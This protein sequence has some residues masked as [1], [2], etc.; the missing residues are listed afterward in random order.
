MTQANDVEQIPSNQRKKNVEKII[1]KIETQK[2]LLEEPKRVSYKIL[3]VKNLKF[4]KIRDLRESTL[5]D[6]KINIKENG[7]SDARVLAVVK[8]NSEDFVVDGNHRLQALIDL[9]I[10]AVPCVVYENVDPYQVAIEGNIAENTYAPMDLFDWL[11]I[12][13]KLKEGG[14]TQQ[15]IGDKIGWTREKIRDHIKIIKSIGAQNLDLCKIN[16]KGR[17]PKDGANATFDFTEGWFRTSGLY[18]LCE[19]YQRRCL[20][21]FI[22]EKCNWSKNKLQ[23]ETSKYKLWQELFENAKDQLHDQQ[24][25]EKIKELIENDTFK[26]IN[27]LKEKINDFN[28]ES[29]NRL[30]C[31]DS[32]QE[33]TKI[34]DA[35]ID[36]VITDPPYGQDY[37]CWNDSYVNYV[38]NDG[39]INDS[40][41]IFTI[42]N[43]ICNILTKKTKNDCH[44]YFFCSWKVEPKY[45]EIIEK[46]F[47]IKN[48]ITWFKGN[49]GAG[50]LV[51]NWGDSTEFIIYAI[52]GKRPLNKGNRKM[53]FLD[54]PRL[55]HTKKI[56]PT[57]KP[58]D[59][60]KQ[61]L[62]V[63]AQP[64]DTICD[65]FM[66]SGST[67]KACKSFQ[68]L[69]YIGIELDPVIFQKAKTFIGGD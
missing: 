36:L 39:V 5:Q 18:D 56:H 2:S 28:K 54:I 9:G 20:Q 31:G 11:S 68:D 63:S 27:Q 12:I 50:D 69:H 46:Y 4:F 41:S 66:G 44:L 3:K 34:E 55:D 24:N 38:G 62:E 47:Q 25:L 42:L 59:L 26:N 22:D 8:M 29:R 57:Q 6:I 21:E 30:I 52:K 13:Q 45:R 35:T 64:N 23:K 32:I 61:L 10:E 67:I 17:A 37:N 48:I 40:E 7:Y 33:L 53:N 14:L 60:I 51:Y 15:E 65:P 58:V 16:Q 43:D 19:K 1:N 49:D